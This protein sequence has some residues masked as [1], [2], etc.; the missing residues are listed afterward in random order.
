MGFQDSQTWVQIITP[1]SPSYR[2]T[3]RKLLNLCES[4][5]TQLRNENTCFQV[6]W[7]SE[8]KSSIKAPQEN[9]GRASWCLVSRAMM[10]AVQILHMYSDPTQLCVYYSNVPIDPSSLSCS[11]KTG[12]SCKWAHT[13]L[14]RGLTTKEGHRVTGAWAFAVVTRKLWDVESILADQQTL[15][16]ESLLPREHGVVGRETERGGLTL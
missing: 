1:S 15:S 14:T 9:P 10:L 11:F 3:L 12:E 8:M 2:T 6:S 5:I 7:E 13:G 16:T 4:Q